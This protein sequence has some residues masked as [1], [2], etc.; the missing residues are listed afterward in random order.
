MDVYQQCLSAHDDRVDVSAL[1][2]TGLGDGHDGTLALVED[3]GR[4]FLRS[5]DADAQGRLF[6]IR[7]GGEI[8]SSL[9]AD[10]FVFAQ[11]EPTADLHLLG[12]ATQPA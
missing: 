8:A 10:N 2:Y 5:L 6:E 4:T 12:A 1:G 9:S 3:S 11:P 7:W